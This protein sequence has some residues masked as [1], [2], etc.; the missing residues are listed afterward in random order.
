MNFFKTLV[1]PLVIA[2]SSIMAIPL[3]DECDKVEVKIETHKTIN[4][5]DGSASALIV[6]GD[7]RSAMFIFCKNDGNVLNEGRFD[8]NQIE[9]LEKGKYLCIVRTRDCT[10]KVSFSID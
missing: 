4:G 9:G 8:N 5:K 6:K 3:R 10:K 1:F 7:T 2:T